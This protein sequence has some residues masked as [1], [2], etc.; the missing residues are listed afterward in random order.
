MTTRGRSRREAFSSDRSSRS[1]SGERLLPV[2]TPPYLR[3]TGQSPKTAGGCSTRGTENRLDEN[4]TSPWAREGEFYPRGSSKRRQDSSSSIDSSR[5]VQRQSLFD[6]EDDETG[7]LRNRHNLRWHCPTR[8]RP[9]SRSG[10]NS[11]RPQNTKRHSASAAEIERIIG[12][13]LVTSLRAAL[14]TSWNGSS[15]RPR[16]RGA[17]KTDTLLPSTEQSTPR[18]GCD[19]EQAGDTREPA[20]ESGN[21]FGQ[22]NAGVL[23]PAA[24]VDGP[25][26]NAT[27]AGGFAYS[28]AGSLPDRFVHDQCSTC[29]RTDTKSKDSGVTNENA[30]AVPARTRCSHRAT[31]GEAQHGCGRRLLP[32]DGCRDLT[33]AETLIARQL[34][35]AIRAAVR[36]EIRSSLHRDAPKFSAEYT[37]QETGAQDA[38]EVVGDKLVATLQQEVGNGDGDEQEGSNIAADYEVSFCEEAGVG[39]AQGPIGADG[40]DTAPSDS[41]KTEISRSGSSDDVKEEEVTPAQ[42]VC[43]VGSGKARPSSRKTIAEQVDEVSARLDRIFVLPLSHLGS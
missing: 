1:S 36:E 16:G 41:L 17:A 39:A 33:T 25:S 26:Q 19:L 5:S 31:R 3:G 23:K 34:H 37:R 38:K 14:E 27:K 28:E 22:L 11:K 43:S 8:R 20:S 4:E 29:S 12:N 42:P 21:Q 30:G 32:A 10:S 35:L 13:W 15:K 9:C 40:D 6:G 18:S 2:A 24:C 7:D